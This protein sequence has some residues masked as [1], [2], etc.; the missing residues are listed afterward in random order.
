MKKYFIQK[1][2]IKNKI[3]E[4]NIFQVQKFSINML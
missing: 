1:Q 3:Q 4:K 2:R